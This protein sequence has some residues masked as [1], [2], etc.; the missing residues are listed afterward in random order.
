MPLTHHPTR[1]TAAFALLTSLAPMGGQSFAQQPLRVVIPYPAGSTV[2]N[3]MRTLA[4]A[5]EQ[6][7]KQA[8]M[9]DFKPGGGTVIGTTAI[10]KAAADGSTIGVVANSLVINAKLHKN[11]PYDALA[12]FEPVAQ[13]VESPQMI[14]VKA[15]SPYRTLQDLLAAAR[16]RAGS[17]SIASVGPGTTQHIAVATL[18][19]AAGVEMVY[20]PFSGGNLAVNAVAGGHVSAVMSNVA[21]LN[22]HL[23]GGLLRPLAVT[24]R[25]R[26]SLMREVPTVAESGFAGY[27]VVVWLGIVAP[28]GTSREVV[29]RLAA[30]FAGALEEPAV[31]S[32]LVNAG[33]V[34]A[35]LGPA[36]LAAHIAEKARLYSRVIDEAGIRLE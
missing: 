21:D 22:T 1:R 13:L 10:A 28:A 6:R 36:A 29:S 12:S 27:D 9:L 18:L 25:E 16:A 20:A 34:P 19:R 2:D 5:V 26:V 14:A 4:P 33:F 3:L 30:A 23:S 35:Y 24:S 8:V 15:D 11:L 17:V 7:W 31:R 32:R